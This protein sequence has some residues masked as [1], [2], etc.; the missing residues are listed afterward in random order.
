MR[1]LIL[2]ICI[3][4]IAA[5]IATAQDDPVRVYPINRPGFEFAVSPDGQTVVLYQTELVF[6]IRDELPT[7]ADLV[8]QLLDLQTGE[9]R[10]LGRT[11]NL[12]AL[13]AFSPDGAT[14]ATLHLDNYIV[15]WDVASGAE[16]G[17]LNA[18]AGLMGLGFLPDNQTLAVLSTGVWLWDTSSGHIKDVL[19]PHWEYPTS[20][21]RQQSLLQIGLAWQGTQLATHSYV[22]DVFMWDMVTGEMTEWRANPG[23]L[24]DPAVR[25]EIIDDLAFGPTG[26]VFLVREEVRLLSAPGGPEEV[27]F[28]FPAL[29]RYALAPDGDTLAW[30][31]P[32]TNELTIA[33]LSAP[34]VASRATLDVPVDWG[35]RGPRRLVFAPDSERLFLAWSVTRERTASGLL[36]IDELP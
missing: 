16:R 17:R 12:V 19:L 32:D 2:F 6:M 34:E 9:V 18:P 1:L 24:G 29:A 36:V 31:E 27:V 22:G 4:V 5:P 35:E 23:D 7:E 21:E 28:E 10:D 20:R 26:L 25:A 3:L 8:V 30:F 13:A 33:R 11:D 14:L 15:L